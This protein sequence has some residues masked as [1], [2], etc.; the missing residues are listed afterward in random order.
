MIEIDKPTQDE[1]D[2]HLFDVF[3]V[4]NGLRLPLKSHLD[5]PAQVIRHGSGVPSLVGGGCVRMG[6]VRLRVDPLIENSRH[7]FGPRAVTG[8]TGQTAVSH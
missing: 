4:D 6:H 8:P 7:R 2:G 5:I 3:Q 1:D